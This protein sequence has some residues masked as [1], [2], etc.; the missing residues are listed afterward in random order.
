MEATA[1]NPIANSQS[2]P[3]NQQ[4]VVTQT[5]GRKYV[6]KLEEKI[7]GKKKKT[8]VLATSWIACIVATMLFFALGP[9]SFI[10]VIVLPYSFLASY[11]WMPFVYSISIY[12]APIILA[13]SGISIFFAFRSFP[14]KLK[15][16]LIL[17]LGIIIGFPITWL[18]F[19][20]LFTVKIIDYV[21]VMGIM[22]LMPITFYIIT[23]K[24]VDHSATINQ[25]DKKT[26][27]IYTTISMI[28]I[29]TEF[30]FSLFNFLSSLH[31]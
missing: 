28:T 5:D 12:A 26:A 8:W 3:A 10:A 27:V 13:L 29:L 25:F 14:E 22:T 30:G 1:Y 18:S 4:T 11:W 17:H 9:A 2:A 19:S 21:L 6:S 15:S 20:G 7:T 24:T 31:L 23:R 16:I